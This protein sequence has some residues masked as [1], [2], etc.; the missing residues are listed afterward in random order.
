[1][2][3]Q[4]IGAILV[5]SLAG[6][7][8]SAVQQLAGGGGNGPAP[9]DSEVLLEDDFSDSSSGWPEA[10]DGDKSAGYTDGGQYLM[11]AL[12]TSQDVWAHPGEDFADVRIEVDAVKTG[13]PD[14]NDFGV[15]C[16]FVDDDNFYFFLISSDGFQIIGKYVGG[17]AIFLSAEKMQPTDAVNQGSAS[18]HVR[19]DCNGQNLTL[20][21]NGTLLSSVTD[22]SFTHGDVGLMTGTFDEPNVSVTFD[23]FVVSKP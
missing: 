18:N 11:R 4:A 10:S 1:M 20:Y 6:L 2:R 14:N 13:G 9:S 21:A 3:Q 22:T 17:D 23:N 5:L 7:A 15:I 12:T 16:R 19:A 8:C